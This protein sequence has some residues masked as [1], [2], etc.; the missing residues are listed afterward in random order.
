MTFK[1]DE[2]RVRTKNG[3][4]NLFTLR[5]FAMGLLKKQNGKLNL[6]RRRKKCMLNLDYLAKVVKES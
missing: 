4:I 1:E 3:A 2:C 6:K 5:K